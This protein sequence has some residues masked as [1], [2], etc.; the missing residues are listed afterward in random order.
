MIFLFLF[1]P[2]RF[3]AFAPDRSCKDQIAVKKGFFVTENTVGNI[4]VSD[5]YERSLEGHGICQISHY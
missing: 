5:R 2:A 4:E 3:L 1:L